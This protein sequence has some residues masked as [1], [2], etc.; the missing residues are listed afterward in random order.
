MLTAL[1]KKCSCSDLAAF[2]PYQLKECKECTRQ[3][4]TENRNRNVEYYREHD[5]K[6]ASD[7]KRKE[8]MLAKTR[9]IRAS[10]AGRAHN[11]VAR[12]V[13]KGRLVRPDKCQ[14]CPATGDIEAH[15]DDHSKLLDVMWLC[16]ICHAARHKELG[17][18]RTMA[19]IYESNAGRSVET[20]ISI[21]NP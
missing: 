13:K 8:T 10:G 18:L 12:A 4:V 2:Y 11:A 6:R 16:P 1:C 14:R 3:R 15:H 17:R 19:K 5:R 7:P 20:T 9:R 21:S